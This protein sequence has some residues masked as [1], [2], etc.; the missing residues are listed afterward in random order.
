MFTRITSIFTLLITAVVFLFPSYAYAIPY[1]ESRTDRKFQAAPLTELPSSL[2]TTLQLQGINLDTNSPLRDAATRSLSIGV[3]TGGNLTDRLKAAGDAAVRTGVEAGL[4]ALGD[5]IT[6]DTV[7]GFLEKAVGIGIE[8][9][10]PIVG[11]L[12]SGFLGLGGGGSGPQ[13]VDA[14]ELQNKDNCLDAIARASSAEVLQHV[15]TGAVYW[16]TGVDPETGTSVADAQFVYDL[17]TRFRELSD[18]AFQDVVGRVRGTGAFQ[19]VCDAFKSDVVLAMQREYY[20]QNQ[21]GTSALSEELRP[22]LQNTEDNCGLE[23]VLND[24]E[25]DLPRFL[26]G[27]WESGGWEAWNTLLYNNPYTSYLDASAELSR[28]IEELREEELASYTANQGFLSDRRCVLEAREVRQID[29]QNTPSDRSDDQYVWWDPAENREISVVRNNDGETFRGRSG[30]ARE[31]APCIQD[32][33]FTPGSVIAYITNTL[34][35]S[36]IRRAEL[37]DEFNEIMADAGNLFISKI[38]QRGLREATPGDFTGVNNCSALSNS[39]TRQLNLEEDTASHNN[40]Y[41]DLVLPLS[42]RILTKEMVEDTAL[43]VEYVNDFNEIDSIRLDELFK[44][45]GSSC[46]EEGRQ[47][48]SNSNAQANDASGMSYIDL[49]SGVAGDLRE[50]KEDVDNQCSTGNFSRFKNDFDTMSSR[51]V[52]Q[53]DASGTILKLQDKIQNIMTLYRTAKEID[54]CSLDSATDSFANS[55]KLTGPQNATP[56]DTITLGW[57]VVNRGEFAMCALYENHDSASAWTRAEFISNTDTKNS[58]NRDRA[59]I[60]MDPKG[61]LTDT[62]SSSG[63][64]YVLACAEG[65]NDLFVEEEDDL[66]TTYPSGDSMTY[67]HIPSSQWDFTLKGLSTSSI[68]PDGTY[69][70]G[71]TLR[72]GGDVVIDSNTDTTLRN[73]NIRVFVTSNPPLDTSEPDTYTITLTAQE[74]IAAQWEN[75]EDA[76]GNPERLTR[77]VE[78]EEGAGD[79]YTLTILNPDGSSAAMNNNTTIS[80]YTANLNSDYEDPGFRITRTDS[81]GNTSTVTTMRN[82]DFVTPEEGNFTPFNNEEVQVLMTIGT[83]GTN[84]TSSLGDKTVRFSLQRNVGGTWQA[85]GL[86]QMRRVQ[87]IDSSAP[88]IS[89]THSNQTATGVDLTWQITNFNNVESCNTTY[90]G[91]GSTAGNMWLAQS[92]SEASR[93]VTNVSQLPQNDTGN[94]MGVQFGIQCEHDGETYSSATTILISP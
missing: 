83:F 37:S 41:L 79:T 32:E 15:A 8:G 31:S 29:G 65:L 9:S 60:L 11:S 25:R 74:L 40:M 81:E 92:I 34:S 20:R 12:V 76:A 39:I 80:P 63:N 7:K 33:I 61:S 46:G 50:L 93:T 24:A 43:S 75:I 14:P 72:Y 70:A 90:S 59:Y 13:L 58:I 62:M 54:G 88:S 26:S 56:G 23:K 73:D 16:L 52:S 19:N 2:T 64:N 27:E 1:P 82:D 48:L 45:V 78:V 55:I 6:G 10:I 71:Y 66:P 89:L 44:T 51:F 94:P 49:A 3:C 69:T 17:N 38:F 84:I 28:N 53:S 68:E 77:T 21:R 86:T 91:A 36:D 18:L 42:P 67:L 57:E 87:V 4:G 47:A 22:I 35:T 30:E 5:W 85:E